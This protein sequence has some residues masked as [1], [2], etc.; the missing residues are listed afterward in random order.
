MLSILSKGQ[1]ASG[2]VRSTDWKKQKSFPV[3]F[4]AIISSLIRLKILNFS[5]IKSFFCSVYYLANLLS[6]F[7]V[8][9]I[10]HFIKFSVIDF[11]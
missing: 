8:S 10:L 11:A 5:E 6:I 2:A 4:Q 1:L 3:E 7:K 9:P